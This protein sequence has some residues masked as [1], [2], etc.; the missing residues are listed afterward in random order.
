MPGSVTG[1]KHRGGKSPRHGTPT[2]MA[3]GRKK[4]SKS[5]KSPGRRRRRSKS[6]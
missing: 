3:G 6:K 1:G 5:P 4:R 2:H